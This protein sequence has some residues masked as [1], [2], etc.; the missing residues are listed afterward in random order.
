MLTASV[1]GCPDYIAV[2]SIGVY[3]LPT[4]VVTTTAS[5]VCAGT[6]ATINSGLSAGNFVS[7]IPDLKSKL[8]LSN[9]VLGLSL[10]M[11]SLGVL[12]ALGPVGKSAA[13]YGSSRTLVIATTA[14]ILVAPFVGLA[15]SA[16]TLSIA[17]FFFGMTVASQDVSMNTHGVTLE[18]KSG[19]RYMSRFHA[20]WSVGQGDQGD[21]NRANISEH[22]TWQK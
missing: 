13:K 3:P 10:L 4:A 12:V 9:S 20:F 14:L 7:R 17:L 22:G 15:N 8:E 18:Q 16:L 11:M 5:G 6:S 1:A 2:K 21:A 19:N